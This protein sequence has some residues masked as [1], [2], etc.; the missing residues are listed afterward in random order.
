[1]LDERIG[2]V[3]PL[4]SARASARGARSGD[5]EDGREPALPR[6]LAWLLARARDELSDASSSLLDPAALGPAML[7]PDGARSSSTVSFMRSVTCAA[8][9]AQRQRGLVTLV[10]TGVRDTM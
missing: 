6:R 10:G 5:I 1:L 2:L 7:E 4:L 9:L 8:S 3:K